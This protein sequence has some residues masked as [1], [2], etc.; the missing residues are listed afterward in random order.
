[1]IAEGD[2]GIRNIKNFCFSWD[3]FI[4]VSI[5][6][7]LIY[8]FIFSYR[9]YAAS[10]VLIATKE[11]LEIAQKSIISVNTL[12]LYIIFVIFFLFHFFGESGQ[13]WCSRL[14]VKP[15]I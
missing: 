9:Y 12:H 4:Q 13:G 8:L 2:N 3:T 10:E 7:M 11:E 5:Q 14:V 6:E 1:M 15:Q